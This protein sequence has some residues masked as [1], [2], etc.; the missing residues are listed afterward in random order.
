M[1]VRQ[2]I[3]H[4]A[5]EILEMK[6]SIAQRCIENRTAQMLT[7]AQRD[8]YLTGKPGDAEYVRQRTEI[9]AQGP[10]GNLPQGNL[11]QGNNTL[12]LSGGRAS[13][14]RRAKRR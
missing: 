8:A 14:G 10:E 2:L 7:D 6:Y 1:L 13:S 5:G 12:K 3:G 11:P 9:H 4:R